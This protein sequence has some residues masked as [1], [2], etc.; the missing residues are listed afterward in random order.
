M[1][2]VMDDQKLIALTKSFLLEINSDRPHRP[3]TLEASLER[4]LGIGS[5]ERVELF[6][7]AEKLFNVHFSDAAMAKI[8]SLQD[9]LNLSQ[10]QQ[11]PQSKPKLSETQVAE[12][13]I[14][15]SSFKTLVEA[16]YRYGEIE[17]DRPHIYLLDEEGNEKIIRYGQ[18]LTN[19]KKVAQG[20]MIRGIKNG[21]TVAIMLPTCEEFFYC[22]FGIL[23][24]GGIPVPIYPPFRMDQI[25]DYAKRE[26]KILSNAGVRILITFQKAEAVSKLL[27]VFITN[28]NE[29]VTTDDLMQSPGEIP[30]LTIEAEDPAL[31]QYTSGST[32]DP[33]GVLLTHFNLLSNL[34]AVGKTIHITA[35]DRVVTWLPLYHDMG[36]IGTWLGSLYYGI[37]VTVLSPLFFLNR[38]ERWLWAIHYYRGTLSAGPNFAYELCV[39]KIN[40]DMIQGLDLSSWRLAFNGAE[41]I[42]PKTMERFA[43]K[44]APYGLKPE[45]LFPVYGL[46]ESTVALAFP[47]LGRVPRIDKIERESF[48]KQKRAVPIQ[49]GEENFLE[50][51]SCGKP[52]VGHEIRIVDD[53]DQ[54]LPERRIGNLQFRGPSAM[55]G[56]YRNPDATQAAYHNGWWNTGDLGYFADEE[57]FITGR[58]KDIIIKAGRNLHS[59]ELEDIA[60]QVTGVRKGCVV[61]FGVSDAQSGSEK[62]IIVAETNVQ[63]AEV[64]DQIVAEIIEKIATDVGMPPDQVVLVAP[65]TIPKTSSGKL[66]RAA[67][68]ESYLL[69]KLGQKQLPAYLQI[70]KLFLKGTWQKFSNFFSRIGRGIYTFY[71]GVV[72]VLIL[73]PLW[74]MLLVLPRKSA[75]KCSRFAA[76]NLLRVIGCRV[77]VENSKKIPQKPVVYVANHASYM[78]T[79]VLM[80]VLPEGVAF[81]GKT[82]L[83]KVPVLKTFIKKLNHLTVD[84]MDFSQSL[85]DVQ[86][87]QESLRQGRSIVIF[88]EGTFT[89]V[90][91]L[92]PFKLGAFKVAVEGDRAICPIALSGTRNI[93]RDNSWLLKP[94]IIKVTVGDLLKANDKDWSEIIRLRTLA[95]AEI[96]KYCGEPT[97]DFVVPSP[98]N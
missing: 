2:T 62:L 52:I 51:I 71:A 56:Y 48:E 36:L 90:S 37:P 9:L 5:L 42:Y 33:K 29:V 12:T 22:F 93:L 76:R 46:A 97:I 87:I 80:A 10:V 45:T 6:H 34:R 14:D 77:Y 73:I 95:R 70:T 43:E 44:F 54:E 78:D 57:I 30:N 96:A 82:E 94:G 1:Q 63:K 72:A 66:R 84:R 31:I 25:E 85:A 23:L 16:L 38:P 92:R 26:A 4:D 75:A 15:P 64:R 18:L 88:P 65:K 55:Q 24:A 47:P 98:F 53:A 41:A 20:L 13:L 21:E 60:G 61:A 7:R 89:Q 19:A 69:G 58:K 83:L 27:K 17:A 11:I 3:V 40:D 91:G 86:G 59:A 28:L 81:V 79:L 8:N 74:L 39:R 50:F 32:S 35:A 68:K 67:C 49:P